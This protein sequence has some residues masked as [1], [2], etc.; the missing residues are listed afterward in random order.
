MAMKGRLRQDDTA[1]RTCAPAMSPCLLL[2]EVPPLDLEELRVHI[3]A[4]EVRM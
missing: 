3:A 1:A 2:E 4:H